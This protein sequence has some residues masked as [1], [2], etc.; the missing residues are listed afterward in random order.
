MISLKG[1]WRMVRVRSI[2]IFNLTLFVFRMKKLILIFYVLS[3]YLA[4]GQVEFL[5]KKKDSSFIFKDG[6]FI[7]QFTSTNTD[8]NKF[9]H[10]NIIFKV[11]S[12]FK[13]SY[14]YISTDNKKYLFNSFSSGWV[15]VDAAKIDSSTVKNVTL[16]VLNGNPMARGVPN[17]SQTNLNYELDTAESKSISGVIENS[18]NIWMHPPRDLFFEI[19]ELNPFPFIRSP[20]KIGNQWDWSLKIGDNWADGRWKIWKGSI[21]NIYAYEITDE[22]TMETPLGKL[23]CYIVESTAK[24]RIG[25]TSLTAYFSPVYGFVRLHYVNIDGSK[26]NLE[27][28]EHEEVD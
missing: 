14:E 18:K 4:S 21:E 1:L 23:E 11:G 2:N 22:K 15:F 3:T 28:I 27:L 7:E 9:N 13:Y 16:T 10:D 5:D 25:N 19:L 24:S 12:T 6:L 26:T 8:V 17:Y 20:Y